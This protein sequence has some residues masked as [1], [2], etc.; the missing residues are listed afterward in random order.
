MT[1]KIYKI[2]S[3]NCGPCKAYENYFNKVAKDFS[4]YEFIPVSTSENEALAFSLLK[5]AKSSSVPTTVLYRDGE[6]VNAK[7]GMMLPDVLSAWINEN[8]EVQHVD[9]SG[10]TLEE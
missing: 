1:I 10:K 5:E 3:P 4:E 8:L 9:I 6:Y 7:K 2:S